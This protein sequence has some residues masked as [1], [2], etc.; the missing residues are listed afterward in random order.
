MFKLIDMASKPLLVLY[1]KCRQLGKNK[2]PGNR[3]YPVKKGFQKTKRRLDKTV[4]VNL[5]A[6]FVC[7]RTFNTCAA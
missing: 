3:D 5:I 2:R 1:N 7:S 6:L 4:H